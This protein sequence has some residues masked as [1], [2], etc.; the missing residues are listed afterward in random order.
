MPEHKYRFRLPDG[1][2]FE[3]TDLRKIRKAHPEARII[4]RI[5]FDAHGAGHLV[6]FAEPPAAPSKPDKS[7]RPAAG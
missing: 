6:P 7:E 5:D 4:G 2:T 1:Q 3:G